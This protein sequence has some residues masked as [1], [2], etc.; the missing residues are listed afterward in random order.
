MFNYEFVQNRGKFL[1]FN[2]IHMSKLYKL[3]FYNFSND[4]YV[5]KPVKPIN[6][7]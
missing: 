5:I 7:V 2:F 3:Y 1:V 6:L 4:H